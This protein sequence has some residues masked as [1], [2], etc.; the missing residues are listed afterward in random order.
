MAELDNQP[1][2]DLAAD[3]R[4]HFIEATGRWAYT[5]DDGIAY[6]FDNAQGAWFPMVRSI[7]SYNEQ[8]IESQQSI[9]GG[10]EGVDENVGI[11]MIHCFC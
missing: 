4:V 6:E 10:P 3:P 1:T 11:N 7:G 2:G 8:L 9:Y 5:A